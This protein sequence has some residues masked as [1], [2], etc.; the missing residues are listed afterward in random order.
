MIKHTSLKLPLMDWW[1]TRFRFINFNWCTRTY[2][3]RVLSLSFFSFSF[4]GASETK[5]SLQR[6]KGVRYVP[7][8]PPLHAP[9]GGGPSRQ[10]TL[11]ATSGTRVQKFRA[12][13]SRAWSGITKFQSEVRQSCLAGSNGVQLGSNEAQTDSIIHAQPSLASGTLH[14]R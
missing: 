5:G 6:E 4:L 12:W 13:R 11:G 10:A 2:S 9:L 7:R 3:M 8:R 14:V 1:T